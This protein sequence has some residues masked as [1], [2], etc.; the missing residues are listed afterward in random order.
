LALLTEVWAFFRSKENRAL[1]ALTMHNIGHVFPGATLPFGMA[2]AV[3]DSVNDNAGGYASDGG[4]SKKIALCYTVEPSFV[5]AFEKSG[6]KF[7]G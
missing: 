3:A 6:S 4:Y 7:E 2:K 5:T 1:R